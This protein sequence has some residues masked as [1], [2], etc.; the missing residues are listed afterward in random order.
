MSDP[1]KGA[2]AAQM[3]VQI[4]VKLT[5]KNGKVIFERPNMEFR[6]RYEISSIQAVF[7]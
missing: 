6:E 5:D 2:T 1:I 4:Q 3:V 7:R